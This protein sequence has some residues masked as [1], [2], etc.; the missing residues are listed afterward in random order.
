VSDLFDEFPEVPTA[1][2]SLGQVYRA[3]LTAEY[4]G[5]YVAVKV[6]RPGV[7]ERIALDTLLMRQ[8]TELIATI[9]TFSE[10][11]SEVLDDWAGRFF[12]V[13]LHRQRLLGYLWAVCIAKQCSRTGFLRAC[14]QMCTCISRVTVRFASCVPS[15]LHGATRWCCT[16][17]LIDVLSFH[18]PRERCISRH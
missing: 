11:W 18:V 15:S 10:T 17:C 8:A 2:A 7:M 16:A 14:A 3:K 13:R 6:Q 9:P 5:G 12:Q 4:G 1:S